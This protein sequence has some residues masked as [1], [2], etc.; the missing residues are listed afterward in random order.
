MLIPVWLMETAQAT[1]SVP[2]SIYIPVSSG[3]NSA[4]PGIN[5]TNLGKKKVLVTNTS[6]MCIAKS[7]LSSHHNLLLLERRYFSPPIPTLAAWMGLVLNLGA[8]GVATSWM[9]PGNGGTA[10]N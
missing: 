6:P 9:L 10:Q 7:Q 2:T 4:Q 1:V 8:A 5:N 3:L